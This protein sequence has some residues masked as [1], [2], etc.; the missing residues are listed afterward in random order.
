MTTD[1]RSYTYEHRKCGP[2]NL[3]VPLVILQYRYD[4]LGDFRRGGLRGG[5]CP[6]VLPFVRLD[7]KAGAG[8]MTFLKQNQSQDSISYH[9]LINNHSRNKVTNQNK[10]RVRSLRGRTKPYSYQQVHYK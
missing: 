6:F 8:V 1:V 2:N 5:K 10:R 4:R 9:K 3:P 7:G